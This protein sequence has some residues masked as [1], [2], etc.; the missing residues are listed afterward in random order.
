MHAE[1]ALGVDRQQALV[2]QRGQHRPA[3]VG[4]GRRGIA[5][6][7]AAKYGH[8]AQR[9]ALE[10]R[11]Q[12]PRAAEYG[13]HAVVRRRCRSR[14]RVLVTLQDVDRVRQLAHDLLRR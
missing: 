9:L 5:P 3:G 2:H 10:R 11:Q 8:R 4:H 12:V 13:L 6:K 14:A 7:A 1:A